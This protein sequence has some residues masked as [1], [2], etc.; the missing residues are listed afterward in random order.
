MVDAGVQKASITPL[1]DAAQEGKSDPLLKIVPVNLPEASRGPSFEALVRDAC[2]QVTSAFQVE[3]PR[4]PPDDE[5]PR[6]WEPR[7]LFYLGQVINHIDAGQFRLN[8]YA[9]PVTTNLVEAVNYSLQLAIQHSSPSLEAIFLASKRV[10]VRFVENGG[11]RRLTIGCCQVDCPSNKWL[12]LNYA[13]FPCP[14][15]G[16]AL[17][18]DAKCREGHREQHQAS[19]GCGILKRVEALNPVVD[20]KYQGTHY[21]TLSATKLADLVGVFSCLDSTRRTMITKF[22]RN[23]DE[24]PTKAS[25]PLLECGPHLGADWVS[26][27]Q[28][29]VRCSSFMK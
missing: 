17:Y 26:L 27:G 10:L 3:P 21:S 28:N 11:S 19:G 12:C 14:D 1:N 4:E 29:C 18:C 15:C 25:E 7:D 23:G 5:E 16:I 8:E 22:L 6:C 9:M 24:P 13:E 20:L 2:V